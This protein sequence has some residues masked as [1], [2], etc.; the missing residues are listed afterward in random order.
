MEISHSVIHQFRFC[1]KKQLIDFI[2][3]TMTRKYGRGICSIYHH[4]QSLSSASN[5]LTVIFV[6]PPMISHM[7]GLQPRPR[8]RS[9]GMNNQRF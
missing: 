8:G 3:K 4:Y 6:A 2:I 7:C 1:C 9:F 5:K